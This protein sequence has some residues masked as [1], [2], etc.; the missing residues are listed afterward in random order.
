MPAVPLTVLPV[1]ARKHR[2]ALIVVVVALLLR[3]IFVLAIDPHPSLA[4]GDVN[5]YL[6][7]GHDLV[8]TGTTIHALSTPPLYLMYV[9]AVQVLV[10]GSPAAGEHATYTEI[11]VLRVL[12]SGLGAALVLLVL[13][14]GRRLFSARV[15]LLAAWVMAISPALII[16][17]GG[18]L[19]ESLFMVLLLGGLLLYER[20]LTAATLRVMAWAGVVLGLATLTRAVVVAFP[21]G[22]ALHLILAQRARWKR[23]VLALLVPYAV[24]L[25]FWTIYNIVEW[26]RFVIG[27]DGFWGFLYQGAEGKEF[28]LELDQNLGMTFGQGS[29]V[30]QELMQ[31]QISASIRSDPGGWLAHRV[32]ELAGAYLQPHNTVYY[33][34]AS[35][36]DAAS[37]WLRHDRTLGGLRDVTHIEAFWPKLALYLFHFS[38]LL[39]GVGGMWIGWRRWR[40]LLPLYGLIA[41]FTGV[42]VLLLALPRYLF[43]LYPVF[44][45]FAAAL[46]VD[47]WAR[48]SGRGRSRDGVRVGFVSL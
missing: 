17:A 28:P 3:L 22:L 16:E 23:L 48:R 30:R 13:L 25:S 4:G 33:G 32:K 24:V 18:L 46:L 14:L 39:L 21:V 12:A 7:M 31:E 1:S 15:G 26:D 19:S 6:D 41:Y 47:L 8:T 40:D 11:Q 35:I 5:W 27:S 42:H 20:G 43:P 29:D 44:W 37:S 45:L 9:G 2:A 10:P 38:G 34:G 36:R